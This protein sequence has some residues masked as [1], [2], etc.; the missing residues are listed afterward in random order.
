MG[1]G[2]ESAA[3]LINKEKE[4][5]LAEKGEHPQPTA[6]PTPTDETAQ[7]FFRRSTSRQASILARGVNSE[8]VVCMDNQVIILVLLVLNVLKIVIFYDP[9]PEISYHS[10]TLIYLNQML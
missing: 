3:N 5:M 10:L 4:A 1:S 7:P 2:K 9:D 8:C 6:P